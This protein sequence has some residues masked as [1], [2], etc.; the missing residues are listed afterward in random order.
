MSLHSFAWRATLLLS[1]AVCP[2]AEPPP[3]APV[4]YLQPLESSYPHSL[5][6]VQQAVRE[7]YGLEVQVLEPMGLPAEAY[8]PPRDRYR[9][10]RILDVLRS[11]RP[12]T[13]AL[14][15][16]I[17]ETDVS[18]TL[19]Q[20]PDW[21]VIGLANP[22]LGTAVV[23]THRLRRGVPRAAVRERA[24]KVAAHE[25]GHMLGLPH[26]PQTDCLMQDAH[27]HV[28]T[29]DA[30][31][32]LCDACRARLAARLTALPDAPSLP[33]AVPAH[34]EGRVELAELR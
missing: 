30:G 13:G 23:S 12:Q 7:L 18:T 5:G 16:G 3:A 31:V 28:G 34:A 17:T 21:G 8:Y 10:E 4:V 33:W 29:V 14:V 6:L 24:A 15:L 25:L 9:A 27:G 22:W 11:R 1:A 2:A 20:K 19:R 32:Q 26:C